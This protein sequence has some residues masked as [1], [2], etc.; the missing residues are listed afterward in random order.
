MSIFDWIEDRRKLKLLNA[1]KSRNPESDGSKGLWTCDTF[2]S[3]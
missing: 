3:R 2:L 1:P